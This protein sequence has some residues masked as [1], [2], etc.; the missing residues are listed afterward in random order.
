LPR[1]LAVGTP[2][3]LVAR[4][5][6]A[7]RVETKV[8]T[9]K[10]QHVVLEAITELVRVIA[11]VFLKRALDSPFIEPLMQLCRIDAQAVAIAHVERDRAISLQ[12][13]D[14]LIHE[15]ERC[16]RGPLGQHFCPGLLVAYRKID[17]ERWLGWIRRPC[18]GRGQRR[19]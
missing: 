5:P 12:V 4:S 8:V 17:V 6:V 9:E 10:L 1:W 11:I 15:C 3:R 19:T 2:E 7:H 18:R 16:I 13:T 14:V